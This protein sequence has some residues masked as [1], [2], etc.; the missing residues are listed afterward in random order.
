MNHDASFTDAGVPS[1]ARTN[2]T[3][4]MVTIQNLRPFGKNLGVELYLEVK[5]SQGL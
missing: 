4:G 5:Q 1:P 2:P 3:D